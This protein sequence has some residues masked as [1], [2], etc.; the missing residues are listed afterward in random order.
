VLKWTGSEFRITRQLLDNAT[1]NEWLE[2]E[3]QIVLADTFRNTRM[4][5]FFGRK[6][7]RYTLLNG[8]RDALKPGG[9]FA[10][11]LKR[12]LDELPKIVRKAGAMIQRQKHRD[13]YT[14]DETLSLVVVPRAIVRNELSLY[15]METLMRADAL[16]TF[17]GLSLRVLREA[18]EAAETQFFE[19]IVGGK[20]FLHRNGKAMIV[21]ADPEFSWH[22]GR[23]QGHYYCGYSSK[24]GR[25]LHNRRD[26]K[27]FQ[28]EMKEVMFGQTVHLNRLEFDEIRTIAKT[29]TTR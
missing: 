24:D 26:M 9:R 29:F 19:Y 17:K 13:L 10:I 2:R 28:K 25:V 22:M 21:G 7:A 3:G 5:W 27:D 6:R 15:L 11:A 4:R 1:L 8:A 23:L 20:H 16:A 12:E 14:N 18:A